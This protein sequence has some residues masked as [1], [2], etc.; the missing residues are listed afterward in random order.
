M[1]Q[2]RGPSF[3]Q[4]ICDRGARLTALIADQSEWSQATFGRDT[5]RG[6]V[7]ALKHL[8]LEAKEAETDPTNIVEYA[9]CF[10]LILD[11]TRRAGFSFDELLDAAATKMVVNKLREW[12]KTVGDVPTMHRRRLPEMGVIHANGG[13]PE[14]VPA[15]ADPALGWTYESARD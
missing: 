12:P 7:G 1:D 5:E 9:D 8:A 14:H 11:A 6:P 4:R 10:L 2:H 13:H 3:V 15:V